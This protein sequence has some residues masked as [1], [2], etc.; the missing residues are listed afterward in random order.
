M[1]ALCN[2]MSYK[3][4]IFLPVGKARLSVCSPGRKSKHKQMRAH[5]RPKLCCASICSPQNKRAPEWHLDGWP[6]CWQD[7]DLH[8]DHMTNIM[9]VKSANDS[10]VLDPSVTCSLG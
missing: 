2:T 7:T 10:L 5:P 6:G 1:H 4:G 8:P 3:P 9:G